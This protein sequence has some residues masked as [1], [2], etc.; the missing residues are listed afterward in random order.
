MYIEADLL[1][2]YLKPTDWLKQ[3][4]EIIITKC[5]L[6]TSVITITEIEFVS[7]RD[8]DDAFANSVLEKLEKLK[9]LKF[10]PLEINILKNAVELRKKYGLNIFDALHAA[11]A[12]NL[13]EEIISSDKAFDKIDEITR[14]DPKEL[15][16]ELIS[17]ENNNKTK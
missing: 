3:Y 17:K 12:S 13:K 4:A 2:A 1:Y 16:E 5:D 14:I 11:T 8:F 9:N 6:K 15:A 10:I 7:K